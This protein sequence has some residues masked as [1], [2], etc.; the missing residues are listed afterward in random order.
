MPDL[1]Y[2][3]PTL[4]VRP[5]QPPS[6]FCRVPEAPAPATD[7][8][9]WPPAASPDSPARGNIPRAPAPPPGDGRL[10][11][12]DF[13]RGGLLSASPPDGQH[14]LFPL[15]QPRPLPC[16]SQCPGRGTVPLFP[17]SPLSRFPSRVLRPELPE[18]G[19]WACGSPVSTPQ[20][21]G[22]GDV[23]RV[24]EGRTFDCLFFLLQVFTSV[25][26]ASGL[27]K[28]VG[29]GDGTK[30][31]PAASPLL[32]PFRSCLPG[33]LRTSC[34]LPARGSCKALA[35]P[36]GGDTPVSLPIQ[37]PVISNPG[38]GLGAGVSLQKAT[39]STGCTAGQGCLLAGPFLSASPVSQ[40]GK[41]RQRQMT[42][43]GPMEAPAC[44]A[45]LCLS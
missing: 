28:A 18:G 25:P 35:H 24:K 14:A 12:L 21:L 1:A 9:R 16:D 27:R 15:P 20:S 22:S 36:H 31:A 7:G 11:G 4:G 34:L 10:P 26:P 30:R 8:P 43:L 41:P 42:W 2:S 5:T 40:T 37:G 29:S 19:V 13:S 44:T 33:Q 45:P 3:P 23:R 32:P 38:G 39:V 17:H 6:P